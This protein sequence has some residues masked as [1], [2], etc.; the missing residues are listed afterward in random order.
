MRFGVAHA[1]HA[2]VAAR[3]RRD[4][5]HALGGVVDAAERHAVGEHHA[6]GGADGRVCVLRRGTGGVAKVDAVA[7]VAG[8]GALAAA[9]HDRLGHQQAAR[10]QADKVAVARAVEERA[11]VAGRV[12]VAR[13]VGRARDGE[14]VLHGDRAALDLRRQHLALDLREARRAVHQRLDLALERCVAHIEQRHAAA[15]GAATTRCGTGARQHLQHVLH[16]L[17]ELQLLL[18]LLGRVDHGLCHGGGRAADLVRHHRVEGA[19]QLLDR[20]RSVLAVSAGEVLHERQQHLLALEHLL[21]GQDT[22]RCLDATRSDLGR[23]G[24]GQRISVHKATSW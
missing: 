12:V 6:R 23:Q 10:Q 3:G 13:L 18:E 2:V 21:H 22:E 20:R 5:D 4:A 14:D 8:V 24:R 1:V 7:E 16:Q 15:T 19:R 9:A 17:H 11:L